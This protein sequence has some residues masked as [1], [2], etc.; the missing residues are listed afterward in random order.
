MHRPLISEPLLNQVNTRFLTHA[1]AVREILSHLLRPEQCDELAAVY[2]ALV[3]GK[4]RA[5]RIHVNHLDLRTCGMWY[6]YDELSDEEFYTP[7]EFEALLVEALEN[8]EIVKVAKVYTQVMW[9]AADIGQGPDRNQIGIW[10]QDD[11]DRFQCQQC[12]HCC[13]SLPDAYNT[14]VLD[15]DVN[16]WQ[17]EGRSDILAHVT[18]HP[19]CTTAWTDPQTGELLPACPWLRKGSRTGNFVC[20]IHTT[21]PRHCAD[22]PH[23]KRHA[24]NTGCLGFET[25]RPFQR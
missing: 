2:E 15:E 18:R 11:M 20:A 14:F 17:R 1:Q 7:A 25:H 4:A 12:G 13:L 21:K 10:V 9:V 22:Y 3:G 16:R 24:F 23:T 5:E 8:A 19:F 6:Q